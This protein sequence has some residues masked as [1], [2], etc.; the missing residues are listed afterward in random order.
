MNWGKS[1]YF[2]QTA[3]ENR[4]DNHLEKQEAFL[5]YKNKKLKQSKSWDFSIVLVKIFPSFILGKVGQE[6]MFKNILARKKS[7][8]GNKNKKLKGVSPRLWSKTWHFS[9][10]LF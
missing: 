4:F 3:Q 10:F 2:R 8:L 6:N 5:D 7:F 1:S 9:L